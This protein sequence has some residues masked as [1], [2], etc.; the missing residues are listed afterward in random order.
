V[1]TQGEWEQLARVLD[2][3]SLA[4]DPR[5]A[6]WADRRANDAALADELIKQ[7]G[8]RTAAEWEHACLDAGVGCVE[9]NT[10]TQAEVTTSD[11]RLRVANL[12]VPIEHPLFGSLLRYAPPAAL[13]ETPG[14]VLPGCTFAQHTGMILSELGRSDEEIADLATRGIVKMPEPS[15]AAR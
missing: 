12:V 6:T 13:S 5:F 11:E 7:L 1:P 15:P 14:P 2:A 8:E 3:P 10:R 4:D 9:V